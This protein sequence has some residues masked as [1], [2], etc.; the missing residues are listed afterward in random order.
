MVSVSHEPVVKS[1]V[2]PTAWSSVVTFSSRTLVMTESFSPSKLNDDE[3]P[4][5]EKFSNEMSV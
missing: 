3:Q 2:A 5:L 4:A 1:H